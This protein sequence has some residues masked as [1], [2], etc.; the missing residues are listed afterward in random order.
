LLQEIIDGCFT[1]IRTYGLIALNKERGFIQWFPN[2]IPV[3]PVFLRGYEARGIKSWVKPSSIE[4]SCNLTTKSQTP[5]LGELHRRTKDAPDKSAGLAFVN[6]VL[7]KFAHNSALR[8]TASL[9]IDR[10]PP[11]FHD[12]FIETFSEPSAWLA[13]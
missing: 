10:F 9:T 1:D 13:A 5:E 4:T 12:W 2:T 8:L 7:L 6:K 3:R 11:V